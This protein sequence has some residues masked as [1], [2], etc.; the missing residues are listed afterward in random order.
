MSELN[1]MLSRVIMDYETGRQK[2]DQIIQN[3]KNQ[4]DRTRQEWSRL[5]DKEKNDKISRGQ[6]FRENSM[7]HEVLLRKHTRLFRR[8]LRNKIFRIREGKWADNKEFEAIKNWFERQFKPG[9]TWANFTFEWDV[10]AIEPLKII[11]PFEWDGMLV[12][13]LGGSKLPDPAAF[14]KQ[15]V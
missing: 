3:I 8:L 9:M 15:E 10:S 13:G 2:D 11:T 12:D 7:P 6:E 4:I 5:S 14:T 1:E